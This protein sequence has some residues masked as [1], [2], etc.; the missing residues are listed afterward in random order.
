MSV[1]VS[2]KAV[3]GGSVVT[4]KSFRGEVLDTIHCPK[5]DGVAF[6][7]GSNG[8]HGTRYRNAVSKSMQMKNQSKDKEAQYDQ[9]VSSLALV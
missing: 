5:K 2:Q 1:R 7:K 4:V 6:L 9:W 3:A 8:V